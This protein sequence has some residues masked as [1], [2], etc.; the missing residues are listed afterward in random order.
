MARTPI[1]SEEEIE[2]IVLD[3]CLYGKDYATREHG[4]GMSTLYAYMQRY[5]EYTQLNAK[6]ME[7]HAQDE[8]ATFG[9]TKYTNPFQRHTYTTAPVPPAPVVDEH[10]AVAQAL[11]YEQQ[12]A[13]QLAR[14]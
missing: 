12:R 4:I 14:R 1:R 10:T 9:R 13:A 11:R 8:L 5:P 7:R 6:Q 2:F 3:A